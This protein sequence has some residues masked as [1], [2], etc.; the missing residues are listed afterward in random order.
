MKIAPFFVCL[1]T[2]ASCNFAP[3]YTRPDVS[4]PSTWRVTSDEYSELVNANWWEELG[5]PTLTTLI[6]KALAHNNDLQIAVWRVCQYLAAYQV[7]KS[8]LLPQIGLNAAA[9]KERLPVDENF[10]PPG[11]SSLTPDYHMFLSLSYELDFWGK[12]R[13]IAAA[14]HYE[15]LAQIEN[16]RTVVLTLIGSVAESYILLRQLDLQLALALQILRARTEALQIAIDRFEGGITSKIEV[17]QARSVY[18]ETLATVEELKEKIPQQ[19]NLLS[20]L[21]GQNPGSIPRGKALNE[22]MLPSKAPS[23]LPADLLS[24]RPDILR[25]ENNLKAAHA[26]IGIAKAAFFP[27]IDF[28]AVYGIDSLQLKSLFQ[29]SSRTW[30]LGGTLMQQ[31]FAGGSLVGQLHVAEAQKQELLFSYEQT[32]LTALQEVDNSLIGL[33]QSKQIFL[34]DQRQVA[35]LKDYL[36]LAW[37]RYYEGQTQY[38]TVLNAEQEE[39]TAE[40]NMVTAQASQFLYLVALYKA[41]GGGWVTRADG[42]VPQEQSNSNMTP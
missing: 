29:N 14:S 5:D 24:R 33:Q 15:Y 22:L 6:Q 17:D 25:A 13:N 26:N 32:I 1:L 18:E 16:R 35:A 41:L 28:G 38:L 11:V 23:C 12:N 21:I 8:P 9:T 10:L 34:A 20:V 37:D 30:S 39:L 42:T 3:K 27:Q 36:Q 19:E 7:A 31:I 40:M 2:F 4:L